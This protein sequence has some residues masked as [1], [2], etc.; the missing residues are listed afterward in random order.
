M[1]K[2][3]ALPPTTPSLPPDL[4]AYY[5]PASGAGQSLTYVPA[6]GGWLTVHY[7]NRRY[8][9]DQS[10]EFA[11]AAP[12]ESGPIPVD[13][14]QAIDVGIDPT[15][16]DTE[17]LV[18]ADYADLPAT[19]KKVKAYDKWRKDLTRWVRQKR[20]LTVYKSRK[21]KMTSVAGE[22]E[23]AFRARLSQVA[24]ERRDLS[25]EKLRRKYGKT[26]T[27]LK[28]RLMRA[29]QVLTREQEQAKAKK[30]ESVIS[31][32]TAILGAFLGRK[33]VSAG[34]V[35]RM[36]TA[37]KSAGRLRKEQMDVTRAQE[38]VASVQSR[39]ADLEERLQQD[40]DGLEASFDPADEALDEIR[41]NART[42]DIGIDVFGL[43]WLPYRKNSDGRMEPDWF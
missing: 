34:S 9:I 12:I 7:S 27:T 4:T 28:D 21:Y 31:F 13:W 41:V 22:A 37:A 14:D 1:A 2:P 32:G 40:I 39:M 10:E 20:P 43:L 24:R 15:A 8:R 42:S 16:I 36:G 11:M 3:S 23:S 26:Y 17:P 35:S 25:I 30:M 6:V 38:T 18:G 33:A 29:E 19:G 5:L